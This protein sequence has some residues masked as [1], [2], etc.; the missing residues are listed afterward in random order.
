MRFVG[1][2]LESSNA[3]VTKER[4]HGSICFWRI[5]SIEVVYDGRVDNAGV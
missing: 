5:G 4:R 3:N 2:M 1:F